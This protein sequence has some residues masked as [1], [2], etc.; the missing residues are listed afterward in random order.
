MRN[1]CKLLLGILFLQSFVV[2]AQEG[3]VYRL[4]TGD[5]ISVTVFNEPE[6]GL[7]EAKISDDGNISV[8][9]LGQVQV[10]GKTVIEV[11]ALLTKLFGDDYLK[12]PSVTVAVSEYRP[13]YI[14]GEIKKPGSYSYR[15]NM[16]VQMAITIAGGFTERA[17]KKEIYLLPEGNESQRRKVTL[18]DEVQPGDVITID[19]SFF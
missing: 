18:G 3:K 9:L 4:S 6:L 10:K 17:S 14:N 13:F 15:T 7:K 19:E 16:T 5:V 1:I 2:L 8:P 11:E 12:K